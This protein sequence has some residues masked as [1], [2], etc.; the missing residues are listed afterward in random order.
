VSAWTGV[1]LSIG[2]LL[3]LVAVWLRL[4]YR[5]RLERVHTEGALN[6][7]YAMRAGGDIR[8]GRGDGSWIWLSMGEREGRRG[9]E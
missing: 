2:Y 5:V 1:V 4:R 8:A 7:I 3:R 6:I 9:D